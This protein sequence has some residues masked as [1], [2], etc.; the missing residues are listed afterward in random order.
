MET[1]ETVQEEENVEARTVEQ[2][3]EQSWIFLW[4]GVAK[5]LHG[6]WIDVRYDPLFYTL[7]NA[8]I[9]LTGK[10]VPVTKSFYKARLSDGLEKAKKVQEAKQQVAQAMKRSKTLGK[11]IQFWCL[12]SLDFL[13]VLSTDLWNLKFLVLWL[14]RQ[15]L[16]QE[17]EG[18]PLRISW[19]S[20]CYWQRTSQKT[21]SIIKFLPS[22]V[23]TDVAFMNETKRRD[24]DSGE[25]Y[26]KEYLEELDNLGKEK[27]R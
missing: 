12:V 6:E 3:Y 18:H 9:A 14:E 5:R 24:K 1:E 20:L 27:K 19:K 8:C 11:L 4:W 7:S 21:E 13:L 22:K 16:L 15:Y 10:E 23:Y 2:Q 26:V 17:L 25:G